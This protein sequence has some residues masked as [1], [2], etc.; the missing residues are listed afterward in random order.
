M[1]FKK[2]FDGSKRDLKKIER[3]YEEV[4]KYADEYA[5]MSDEELKGQTDL[6]KK[7][8]QDGESLDDMLPRAFATVREA[9]KRVLGLYPYKVQVMGG[10]VLHQGNLA[11]M[12]TGEG[13]TLTETLPVYLN[14]ITGKGVHVVTVNPY[15]SERDA[16][17]MGQVFEWMGLT[18]GVNTEKMSNAEKR[19]A[20]ACD[21]TYSTND[22]LA[23]DYLRDNM[24]MFAED[25]TQRG[26]NYVIVDEADSI[27]IDF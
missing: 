10:I 6:F 20:Y 23:F 2:F 16:A 13:K 18:V 19:E 7:A 15:L 3:L 9:D 22:E 1:N 12:H 5:S 21:I 25:T 26:L 14:A 24:A 27:L 11:E 17:E 8:Y 4:D